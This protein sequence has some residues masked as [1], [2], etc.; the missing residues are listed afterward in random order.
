MGGQHP[1]PAPP[2]IQPPF[3]PAVIA[4][5]LW[6]VRLPATVMSKH[7]LECQTP[8]HLPHLRGRIRTTRM[9][10]WFIESSNRQCQPKEF[11]V[12]KLIK[13]FKNIMKL[14]EFNITV[15]VKNI[16][17]NFCNIRKFLA[18]FFLK[19]KMCCLASPLFHC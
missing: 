6:F 19:R 5:R 17:A 12:K 2:V 11:F 10:D 14:P 15:A 4:W 8:G 16:V 9:G 1:P 13:N 3:F 7:S 18:S